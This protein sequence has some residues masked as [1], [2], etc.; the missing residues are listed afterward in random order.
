M[1][2]CSCC[3]LQLACMYYDYSVMKQVV[4][5]VLVPTEQLILSGHRT[6][7]INQYPN[8]SDYFVD[9]IIAFT[10][11]MQNLHLA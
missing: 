2:F 9:F 4:A 10:I 6:E 3:Q 7:K 8:L 1:M 5:K 11:T